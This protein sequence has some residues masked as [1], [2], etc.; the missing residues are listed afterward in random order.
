MNRKN[1]QL[2]DVV[3]Y[4][5]SM[6]KDAEAGNWDKVIDIEVQRNQLLENLFSSSSR[7]NEIDDIDSKIHQIININKK[8]ESA[9]AQARDNIHKDITSIS[10][11]RQA[12]GLYAQNTG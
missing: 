1:K 10:K 8:I 12:V 7:H 6:L 9:A 4:S 3:E 5:E 2:L 11:G